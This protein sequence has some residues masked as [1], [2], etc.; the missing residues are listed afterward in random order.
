MGK[1]EHLDTAVVDSRP[2]IMYGTE[3]VRRRRKCKCGYRFT[4]YEFTL[5]HMIKMRVKSLESA[6]KENIN[7]SV[8]SLVKF[9][10]DNLLNEDFEAQIRKLTEERRVRKGAA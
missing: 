3:T 10:I 4:T 7:N 1:C 2:T 8:M 6:I 5:K 9:E